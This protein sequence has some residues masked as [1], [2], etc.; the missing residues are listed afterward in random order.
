MWATWIKQIPYF[1]KTYHL[2]VPD[3]RGFGSSSHPGDVQASGTIGDMVGD[4]VCVLE[5]AGV[6]KA[7]CVGH[8]WGSQVCWEAARM[9]PDLFEAVAG[10][11]VPVSMRRP[12]YFVRPI[13]TPG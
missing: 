10:I 11:T 8:D 13:L 7:T 1:E 9:R 12:S 4:M 3:Q 2:L 6:Q 5:H